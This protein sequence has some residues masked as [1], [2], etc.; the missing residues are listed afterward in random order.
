MTPST[1]QRTTTPNM[2]ARNPWLASG[3]YPTSHFNGGA[4][5]SVP[6]AGPVH[7]RKLTPQDVKT[8]SIV[9]DSNPAVKKVGS[10]T[11]AFASGA[12]GIQKILLTENIRGD[13]LC[14]ISRLREARG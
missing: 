9:F 1:A 4:T 3:P 2:P 11:I 6:F 14:G 10:E 12:V 5:D 13:Q 8:V 7:G